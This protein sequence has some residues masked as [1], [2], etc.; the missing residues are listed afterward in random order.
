MGRVSVIMAAFNA[1]QYINSSIKSVLNQT[2]KDWE[3]LI[4]NDGSTDE[5]ENIIKSFSDRRIKYFSQENQG[6]SKARNIGLSNMLGDYFCFLDADDYMPPESLE[7]R[8]RM[9]LKQPSIE[10]IDGIVHIY[11]RDFTKKMNQWEPA[12]QGNP[13]NQLLQ[14]SSSCFF[15]PTWMIRRNA[16]QCYRFNENISHG[17]DL[18]FF[19]ELA[20]NGG[21]YDFVNEVILHYRK[22]HSSAMKDLHGLENGYHRIYDSLKENDKIPL[23]QV[24]QFKQIAGRI[25]FKSYLG[26]YQIANAF[27]SLT[28]KW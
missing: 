24:E 16:N 5:T 4:I 21:K 15:S 20:L 22:G 18:L 2:L 12:F 17:E 11:N 8:Y 10:F 23:E 25:I 6:V 1:E 13:L 28:R 27:L 9:F 3:L 19:I 7:I 14:I 26:N